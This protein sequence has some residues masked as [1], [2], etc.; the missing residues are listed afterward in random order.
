M[1]FTFAG[2]THTKYSTYSLEQICS[3][4]WESSEALK[5]AQLLNWLVNP[6][7]LPEK[8]LEGDLNEEHFNGELDESRDHNDAD[9]DGNL[10]RNVCSRNVGHF[11]RLKKEW[12]QG[13][14][15]V[16]RSG[17]HTEPHAKPEIRKLLNKYKDEELH[18]F[19]EGRKYDEAD[20]DNFSKGYEK[21]WDR[22]LQ[23]WITETTSTCGLLDDLPNFNDEDEEGTEQ[24]GGDDD[25]EFEMM[26]GRRYMVDGELVIETEEDW[27][28]EFEER[29][30]GGTANMD[31]AEEDNAEV[32]DVFDEVE[33]DEH[34]GESR[35]C[36]SGDDDGN[37]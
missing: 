1:A 34:D 19:R 35:E 7:G 16:K 4:E 22:A 10:M 29:D 18:L 33:L 23:K 9:W 12:I 11:M 20:V 37:V 36:D 5:D 26:T 13:L 17:K 24:P 21:L 25:G 2:S 8:F 30:E 32:P 27:E 6:E 3:L 15:L 14:G 28:K 31:D